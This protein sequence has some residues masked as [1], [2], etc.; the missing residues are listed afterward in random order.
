M[1]KTKTTILIIKTKHTNAIVSKEDRLNAANFITILRSFLVVQK[2][3]DM[4][5]MSLNFINFK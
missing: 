4:K 1:G 2:I 3:V 5:N